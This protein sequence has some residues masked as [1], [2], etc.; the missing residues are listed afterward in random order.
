MGYSFFTGFI[1][2]EELELYPS[3]TSNLQRHMRTGNSRVRA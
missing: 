2:T 1:A 3:R